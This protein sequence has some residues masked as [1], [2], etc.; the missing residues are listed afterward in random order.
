MRQALKWIDNEIIASSQKKKVL[1]QMK[2][3]TH[4]HTHTLTCSHAHTHTHTHTHTHPFQTLTSMDANPKGLFSLRIS[5]LTNF[6]MGSDWSMAFCLIISGKMQAN[7]AEK[8]ALYRSRE[9][10]NIDVC[11]WNKSRGTDVNF[12]C[13]Q[14]L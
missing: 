1:K 9:S 3:D 11:N 8:Y 4:T 12:T 5:K 13:N 6:L 14:Y 7:L 2:G 10:R